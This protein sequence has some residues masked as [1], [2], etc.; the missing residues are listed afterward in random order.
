MNL[1]L[2]AWLDCTDARL[3]ILDKDSGRILLSWN[4]RQIR[5]AVEKGLLITSDLELRQPSDEE[6]LY[7]V[8]GMDA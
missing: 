7:L 1:L 5:L 2:D 6:L 4:A 3:R 8:A